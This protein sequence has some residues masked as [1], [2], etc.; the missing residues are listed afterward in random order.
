[1]PRVVTKD[2][3]KE[4]ARKGKLPEYEDGG[5]A[6]PWMPA[7][8]S[9]EQAQEDRS[10]KAIQVLAD[11]VMKA[12]EESGKALSVNAAVMKEVINTVLGR[13]QA[14]KEQP[15][16]IPKTELPKDWTDAE[17]EVTERDS[18]YNIRKI[19]FRKVS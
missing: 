18:N 11:A 17:V 3:L 12:V 13:L 14:M 6:R 2:D 15:I 9:H 1:M 19:H 10:A 16:V 8:A 4:M 5:K 7:K